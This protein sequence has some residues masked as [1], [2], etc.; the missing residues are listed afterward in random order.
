MKTIQQDL[1]YN[2]LPGW[3]D[4]CGSESSTLE[5]DVCVWRYAPLVVLATQEDEG[6]S[7]A[8]RLS[9]RVV[10]HRMLYSCTHM[11]TVGIKGLLAYRSTTYK[12]HATSILF[13]FCI[14]HQINVEKHKHYNVVEFRLEHHCFLRSGMYDS[15]WVWKMPDNCGHITMFRVFRNRYKHHC[16]MVTLVPLSQELNNLSCDVD[17]NC[18]SVCHT[19]ITVLSFS[20]AVLLVMEKSYE[21]NTEKRKP[22]FAFSK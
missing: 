2:N 15:Y 17:R 14:T 22:C 6:H 1:S 5:T 10:W 11:A 12:L 20:I 16:S 7:D 3:G 4:N 13:H 19:P 8:S 18:P 21:I 9:I